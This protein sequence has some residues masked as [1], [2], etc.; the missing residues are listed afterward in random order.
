MIKKRTRPQTCLRDPSADRS[1]STPTQLEE[2]P[3]QDD[4]NG[5]IPY[6][7]VPPSA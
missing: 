2:T 3:A 1:D 4:G 7:Y 6:V 5:E